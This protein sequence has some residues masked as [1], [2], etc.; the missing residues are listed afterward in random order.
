[1]NCRT[2]RPKRLPRAAGAAL[3]VTLGM[4]AATLQGCGDG[5]SA[6]G[7]T[8]SAAADTTPSSA[9]GGFTLA[10]TQTS[11]P[12]L[13]GGMAESRLVLVRDDGFRGT[14]A[15]AVT[16]VPAGL[17]ATIE[18]TAT[19][20]TT[21]TLVV[22]ATTGA[23]AGDAALTV[24][25]T[26]AGRA[27]Q[28]TTVRFAVA[29]SPRVA[30]NVTVDFSAC[31]PGATPVW[32]AFQDGAE[33]WTQ[34]VGAASVYRFDVASGKGGY[35]YATMGAGRTLTV[36]YATRDELT[37]TTIAVCPVQG[38]KA[39]SGTFA[40]L[41]AGQVAYVSLGEPNPDPERG[42]LTARSSF[43]LA[44][45]A[46]GAHDLV[47]YRST[48]PS[49]AASERAVIRRD[50]DVASGGT[51]GI[52]DFDGAE[53]FAP[54]TAQVRVTGSEGLALGQWMSYHTGPA[55]ELHDLYSYESVGTDFTMRG[56]P[57]GRQRA[58]DMHRL[59]V[60]ATVG[61]YGFRAA[62]EV[63][64]TLADRVVAFPSALPSPA[65]TT[66]A[67]GHARLQASL[68]LPPEY[69]NGSMLLL[70][71]AYGPLGAFAYVS[72]TPG[73]L[74]G[75]DVTLAVPDLSG[76]TG[77]RSV[78]LPPPGTSVGWLLQATGSTGAAADGGVCAENARFVLASLG[79]R[80]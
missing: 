14:I 55:C 4:A 1:M 6:P 30:G 18:P 3:A 13:Q 38:R 44:G 16:D 74:A 12:I 47:A 19:T 24:T 66:P 41:L 65:I 49:Y 7:T 28:T 29:P 37:R 61:S 73:W 45:V 20:G 54:A 75:A 36:A 27:G 71:Y 56:I 23:P 68:T 33:G 76:A 48:P 39:V 78:F 31:P 26:A 22:T 9:R 46:D 17:T 32:F 5:T 52:I 50:L 53:A 11:V 58:T 15:L 10:G 64:H 63:F 43:T 21:A 51:L 57:A 72:A 60:Y 69:R 25:A 77:W 62:S 79:G 70:M 42:P 34:I 35:A 59:D 8:R 40:G 80:T 67:G 2:R